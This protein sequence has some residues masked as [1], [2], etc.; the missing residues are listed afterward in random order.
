MST[1]AP[2]SD[3]SVWG[4]DPSAVTVVAHNVTTRYLAY[5][6]DAILGLVMLPFNLS[7]LG[8]AAYGLWMLTTS[9]TVYFD[10]LDL[11]YGGALVRFVAQYRA[12]RN[13][14]ALNEVLSTFSLVYAL[15]GATAYLFVIVIALNLHLMSK[16]TPSEVETSRTLL[17]IIG[18]N[19]AARFI[20]GVY[21]GIIV[22]FQRYHLNN[23]TS[24]A[25]SLA[26]AAANV[27]VLLAGY[28]IV[29]LV[30][31]TTFVRILTLFVYRSNA[32]RTFPGLSI[33]WSS[34]RRERFKEVSGF[35]VYMLLL[36][37]AYKVNYSID[38]I[39]VGAFLGPASVALWA[40]AQRLTDLALRLSN[41][42]GDALFPIVVDC[43]TSQHNERLR[44][45][46]LEGTRLS[47]A[48]VLPIGGGLAVMAEP[49]MTAWLG[50]QFTMTAL[51]VQ[52]LAFVVV[53]R[54][55]AATA[56]IVLKGAGM[57]RGLTLLIAVMGVGNFVLSLILV[58][59]I[60]LTGVAIGT[61]I[62][63]FI[64]AVAALFPTACRR[65]GVGVMEVLRYSVWPAVWPA[66]VSLTA[67][68]FT[69]THLPARLSAVALQLAFGAV[70]YFG[71]FLVAVGS[72]GRREYLR[73]LDGLLRRRAP[74]MSRVG[75]VNA[76]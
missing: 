61:A 55:G 51:V 6:I 1:S 26:V 58:K 46:F 27:A 24:I 22:G 2:P 68:A 20:F 5:V 3:V 32:Y 23:L 16:L 19:V 71:L 60:G 40:P 33:K 69:Q 12:Q 65:V 18:A 57:H 67:L 42:L 11:G 15:I 17:L 4:H 72:I 56:S 47:L 28:G 66:A 45:V 38:V 76:S 73:H 36:D 41:Q 37:I 50:R 9:F 52:I 74:Q 62:P 48:T 59:S 35:S 53:V 34:F 8:M 63:V 14:K 49:L 54:V 43:D 10:M 25:T 13:A 64:I 70:I 7:H 31:T 29:A 44:R 39:V 75:T 21:G 30:A